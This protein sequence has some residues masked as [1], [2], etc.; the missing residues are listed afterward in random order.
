MGSQQGTR[1]IVFDQREGGVRGVYETT[2]CFAFHHINAW[3]DEDRDGDLVLDLCAYSDASVIDALYLDRLRQAGAFRSRIPPASAS[4]CAPD[5]SGRSGWRR[6]PWSCRASP[7][8]GTTAAP[9][10]TRTA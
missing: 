10:G 2:A 6:S 9:T 4:V 1:F 3:E 5:A 7:T 8:S